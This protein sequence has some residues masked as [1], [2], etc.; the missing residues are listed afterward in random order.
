MLIVQPSR[1]LLLWV[2]V[3]SSLNTSEL[4]HKSLMEWLRL[5]AYGPYPMME[6]LLCKTAFIASVTDGFNFYEPD[7]LPDYKV[8]K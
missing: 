3:P 4:S 2:F 7:L 1:P 8:F 6:R 5:F